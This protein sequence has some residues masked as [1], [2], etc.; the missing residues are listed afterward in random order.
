MQ[1]SDAITP[2]MACAL[3]SP[4]SR[5]SSSGFESR[6]VVRQEIAQA[7]GTLMQE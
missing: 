5:Q 6:A 3:R 2:I 1:M 4:S 7:E